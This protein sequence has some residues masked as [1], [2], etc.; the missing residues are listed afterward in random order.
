MPCEARTFLPQRLD[1][2][3]PV[4]HHLCA[5]IREDLLKNLFSDQ[6]TKKRTRYPCL[7][8]MALTVTRIAPISNSLK[9]MRIGTKIWRCL[10]AFQAAPSQTPPNSSQET[11][12]QPARN[13]RELCPYSLKRDSFLQH[14][15]LRSQPGSPEDFRRDISD[16]SLSPWDSSLLYKKLRPPNKAQKKFSKGQT[17][18]KQR[19]NPKELIP[20]KFY[21]I[22]SE[23]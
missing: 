22:Y 6:R 9:L 13:F 23:N 12:W 10:A 3:F 17:H 21:F 16:T 18:M 2:T 11:S 1:R 19:A 8:F 4:S 14:N 20:K 7:S 15:I 5:I